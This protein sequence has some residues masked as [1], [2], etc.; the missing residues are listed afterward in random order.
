M[1]LRLT[2][3]LTSIVFFW[4]SFAFGEI[5]APGVRL[6]EPIHIIH[7]QDAHA[8]YTAQ[9]NICELIERFRKEKGIDL[10]FVEGAA[11][12]LDRK[13]LEF[14]PDPSINQKV[15]DKLARMGELSGADLYLLKEGAAPV[16]FVG[17]E[18][19]ALYRK[20]L[21]L[22]REVMSRE[23][24]SKRWIDS[25]RARL[26][27]EA[28]RL[29]NKN[30]LSLL[31]LYLHSDT[32]KK[33]I[34]LLDQLSKKQLHR[35][36]RD[37]RE[38]R[39][40]PNLVRLLRLMDDE[41]K[42]DV[43]AASRE[44]KDIEKKFVIPAKAGIQG[45][46]E[47]GKN[48]RF[49]LEQLY[50]D[51]AP[52][53]FA[54]EKYPNF[55]RLAKNRVYQYELKSD[56]FFKE[57]SRVMTLL[58]D[59][60][61][62]SENEKQ[63]V[64]A[65]KNFILTSKL[66]TLELTREE[67]TVIARSAKGATRQSRRDA[68]A[69]FYQAA[70]AREKTFITRIEQVLR[71]KKKS[72]AIVI[73]GGFHT[74]GLAREFGSHGMRHELVSPKVEGNSQRTYVNSLLGNYEVNFATSEVPAPDWAAPIAIDEL[75]T[76]RQKLI[77][78]LTKAAS[79]G[80][81]NVPD[82]RA[83]PMTAAS[84]TPIQLEGV[85]KRLGGTLM[86]IQ[87]AKP[88]R[89]IPGYEVFFP[90]AEG[91][92]VEAL[93]FA[94]DSRTGTIHQ[95][96]ALKPGSGVALDVFNLIAQDVKNRGL[97][98]RLSNVINP[99]MVTLLK[100][101][102]SDLEI[103]MGFS[104]RSGWGRS[105]LQYADA[106]LI[107]GP[108][109]FRDLLVHNKYGFY[110][111]AIRLER[112]TE[113]GNYR[114]SI[115]DVKLPHET[116]NF[117]MENGAVRSADGEFKIFI[118]DGGLVIQRDEPIWDNT[119]PGEKIS[120]Y[121][122]VDERNLKLPY[123]EDYL[124][125][126]PLT[127]TQ[128]YKVRAPTFYPE[129]S[130]ELERR[131]E[132]FMFRQGRDLSRELTLEF[133][134]LH[135]GEVIR[136]RVFFDP[137]GLLQIE[138]LDGAENYY[139]FYDLS[140][141]GSFD[142]RAVPAPV[143]EPERV[144]TS[145]AN[146][147]EKKKSDLSDE[148]D[149]SLI[150]HLTN[151]GAI[152]GLILLFGGRKKTDKKPKSVELEKKRGAKSS[153]KS[154]GRD[155]VDIAKFAAATGFSRAQIE[156][157]NPN[158]V[159]DGP[160]AGMAQLIAWAYYIQMDLESIDEILKGIIYDSIHRNNSK[161]PR[162][163]SL[164]TKDKEFD[165]EILKGIEILQGLQEELSTSSKK[166]FSDLKKFWTDEKHAAGRKSVR[167]SPWWGGFARF[168]RTVDGLLEYELNPERRKQ[169]QDRLEVRGFLSLERSDYFIDS[170]ADALKRFNEK[171]KEF[172]AKAKI[173]EAALD[174]FLGKEENIKP[175][176]SDLRLLRAALV[177]K[178]QPYLDYLSLESGNGLPAVEAGCPDI[179]L[180]LTNPDIQ[181][182][183]ELA[184]VWKLYS[185]D[186]E[187]PVQIPIVVSGGIR[188]W[189]HKHLIGDRLL[190]YYSGSEEQV[191]KFKAEGTSEAEIIQWV[192]ERE[193]VSKESIFLE[194]KSGNLPQSFANSILPILNIVEARQI[195]APKIQIVT[196]PL[197]NLRSDLTA[198][199][200][201]EDYIRE[202]GWNVVTKP[203]YPLNPY[204]RTEAGLI[205]LLYYVLGYPKD[206]KSDDASLNRTSEMERIRIY[207]QR[208]HPDITGF[209]FL[210]TPWNPE[211][212]EYLREVV[213][214]EYLKAV[215]RARARPASGNSLGAEPSGLARLGHNVKGYRPVNRLT[216]RVLY[217][218]DE[219]VLGPVAFNA[220]A[221]AG[222]AEAK[223]LGDS[224]TAV[225]T[226]DYFARNADALIKVLLPKDEI[227]VLVKSDK[228]RESIAPV[229]TRALAKGIRVTPVQKL[230]LRTELADR[231][232]IF[233]L[234]L[235]LRDSLTVPM[236]DRQM[237]RFK[238]DESAFQT[239]V[240]AEQALRKLRQ[241]FLITDVQ[242]RTG[243]LEQEGVTPAA[244]F[245]FLNKTFLN[246][247]EGLVQKAQAETALQ[248]AA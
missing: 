155:E 160:L 58:F 227:F 55:S 213:F 3:L 1:F 25:E 234:E 132:A 236:A 100:K 7:I 218:E 16:Q 131:G 168:V 109:D 124:W 112:N 65:A 174:K 190:E 111:G 24:E 105:D 247:I 42:I 29:D 82:P 170:Q 196:C 164:D 169:I 217:P 205:E 182:F 103:E 43:A 243:M 130:F 116:P 224:L 68:S 61:A 142:I 193:G 18:D 37:P 23:A 184:R 212:V 106:E 222:P 180:V 48:P 107:L 138:G 79:L 46:L 30:L 178:V 96:I 151:A 185:T 165:S 114:L 93:Y 86:R 211:K 176:D 194:K 21:K 191:E 67:W 152:G 19:A 115:P 27:R 242:K 50:A 110:L 11:G 214:G 206:Y 199:K 15:T 44:E 78:K 104:S 237:M 102:S 197:L 204:H 99:K 89:N 60:L 140:L 75:K 223:S 216:E 188:Q 157:L 90:E 62:K 59:A 200:Q 73:T 189:G 122:P 210:T 175:S 248:H 117:F 76:L 231:K 198:R 192:L 143:Q 225:V 147:G 26:D 35:D 173:V 232:N 146:F 149:L 135:S 47:N 161:T 220:L 10:V 239:S 126:E 69:D 195:K 108:N 6:V 144:S 56:G 240:D 141:R 49:A 77:L 84:V 203:I 207:S 57:L 154:L 163:G 221:G 136:Q 94:Y 219:T 88:Y 238:W 125:V 51:L 70:I 145:A 172:S 134:K 41:A 129:A 66:K 123:L 183:V 167:R 36:F 9:K 17:L 74:E 72:S 5:A 118:K 85:W 40:F 228:D 202:Q 133:P 113:N 33:T 120:Y 209:N 53:G 158:N 101:V 246:L 22:F 64:N 98:M 241:F 226:K 87:T 32:S 31:R 12:A 63:I 179:F 95:M 244:G 14:C 2:A 13:Y 83:L 34:S 80:A 39:E 38:Q 128:H 208:Q 153:G 119:V 201:W 45:L 148:I 235:L 171:V 4:N 71:E 177:K 186:E 137:E 181:T 166:I 156:G 245:W 139:L 20:N 81:E 121:I 150:A 54:F 127:G 233:S 159:H 28:S 92:E 162:L 91:G 229:R 8:N 187:N 97:K 230:S 215:E 52:Q